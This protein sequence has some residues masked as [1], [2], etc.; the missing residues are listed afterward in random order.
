MGA[1]Y[2]CV[3]MRVCVGVSR[4]ESNVPS[5]GPPTSTHLLPF[6]S[7]VVV[8]SSLPIRKI[9]DRARGPNQWATS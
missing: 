9:C 2:V 1:K 5:V 7:Y 6:I 8:F 3:E 4:G